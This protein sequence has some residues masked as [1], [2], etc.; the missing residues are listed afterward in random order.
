VATPLLAATVAGRLGVGS[1][2]CS[3]RPLVAGRAAT[4]P[5]TSGGGACRVLDA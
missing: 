3:T 2:C 5:V 4:E 1:G